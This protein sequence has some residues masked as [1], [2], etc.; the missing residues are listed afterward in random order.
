MGH[1]GS[2]RA[3][4]RPGEPSRAIQ[5][6]HDTEAG[7]RG[8]CASLFPRFEPFPFFGSE[9]PPGQPREQKIKKKNVNLKKA[10]TSLIWVRPGVVGALDSSPSISKS[11]PRILDLEYG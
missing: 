10:Y 3:P 7:A 5:G 11:G 2:G 1:L 9:P 6:A 4:G 8:N